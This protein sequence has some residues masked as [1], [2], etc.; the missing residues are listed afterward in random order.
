MKRLL[1]F[2]A[3]SISLYACQE[4]VKQQDTKDTKATKE[5][6]EKAMARYLA[7]NQATKEQKLHFDVLDVAYYE[8][9]SVYECNFKVKMTLPDGR[10]TVGYMRHKIFK[11]SLATMH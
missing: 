1:P 3:L 5:Q 6:L 7:G 4:K 2:I 11:D 8:E 9:I 10:D